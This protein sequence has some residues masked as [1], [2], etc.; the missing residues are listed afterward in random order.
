MATQIEEIR[1]NMTQT[2]ETLRNDPRNLNKV[3]HMSK[4]CN[5]CNVI[6]KESDYESFDLREYSENDKFLEACY[7]MSEKDLDHYLGSTID[8]NYIVGYPIIFM[9]YTYMFYQSK[10]ENDLYDQYAIKILNKLFYFLIFKD[11]YTVTTN[12]L[13]SH[14]SQDLIQPI[15][16]R[17]S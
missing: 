5:R 13:D 12:H 2:I 8:L 7:H 16:H 10:E 14:L 15:H 11:E 1:K 3:I 17:D 9:C 4:L 6:L